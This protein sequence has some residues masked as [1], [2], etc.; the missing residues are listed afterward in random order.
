MVGGTVQ[1]QGSFL[2]CTRLWVQSPTLE[3]SKKQNQN[4]QNKII[5]VKSSGFQ[6]GIL[7]HRGH[8]FVVPEIK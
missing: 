7:S 8:L 3:N 6:G 2:A 1:W 5:Q 4:K